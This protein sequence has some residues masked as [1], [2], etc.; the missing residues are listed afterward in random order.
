MK[1]V[2]KNVAH[3]APAK[4]KVAPA[5][6][7]KRKGKVAK[8]NGGRPAGVAALAATARIVVLP[9]GKE[10][11]RNKGTGPHAR[12]AS[13]LKAGTVGAFL[14]LQPGWTSTLRRAEKQGFIRIAA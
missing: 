7:A 13:L 3:V 11:P 1:T 10:N 6:V 12:Y 14:K 2:Q 8:A 4:A 9:A 5:K